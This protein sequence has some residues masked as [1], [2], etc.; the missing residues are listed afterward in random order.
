MRW[1]LAVVDLSR[2]PELAALHGQVPRHDG[3]VQHGGGRLA[4]VGP[5]PHPGHHRANAGQRGEPPPALAAAAAARGAG[6]A[7]G[8]QVR[9]PF[10]P[11][12]AAQDTAPPVCHVPLPEV[13]AAAAL[14]HGAADGGHAPQLR[15]PQLLQ[16]AIDGQLRQVEHRRLA[17][18]GGGG[19]VLRILHRG[20]GP[21]PL[22]GGHERHGLCGRG[23][24]RDA[25]EQAEACQEPEQGQHE[26]LAQGGE[27]QSHVTGAWPGQEEQEDDSEGGEQGGKHQHALAGGARC[28]CL[29][30]SA[31]CS[32]RIWI[33]NSRRCREQWSCCCYDQDRIKSSPLLRFLSPPDR[34][35]R[36]GDAMEWNPLCDREE[37]GKVQRE[38]VKHTHT[39]TIKLGRIR[40]NRSPGI[41]G[42]KDTCCRAD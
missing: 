33:N 18:A 19:R 15:R 35:S 34:R 9:P 8:R 12:G 38:K 36:A 42:T 22:E 20:R 39:H 17:A 14:A 40:S 1:Y 29:C 28:H 16:N 5:G 24:G 6:L 11:G 31:R 26:L 23:G 4:T 41:G 37:K 30:R 32:V 25:A 10:V 3:I 21:L 7:G 27:E 13:V 2:E